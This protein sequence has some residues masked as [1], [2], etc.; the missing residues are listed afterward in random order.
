MKIMRTIG[1]VLTLA[2]TAVACAASPAEE[3]TG[4]SSSAV[5]SCNPACKTAWTDCQPL[6][7]KTTTIL[8]CEACGA[9]GEAPCDSSGP[10]PG[11]QSIAGGYL[12]L[13]NGLCQQ[14]GQEV[15]Q[16]ACGGASGYCAPWDIRTNA[17]GVPMQPLDVVN[18]VCT[19]CGNAGQ[20]ACKVGGS[21]WCEVGTISGNECYA[22]T[23][24]QQ[25]VELCSASECNDGSCQ[26]GIVTTCP[27]IAGGPAS[28][29]K[30]TNACGNRGGVST[31]VGCTIE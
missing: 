6:P 5:N 20:T 2:A 19:A 7:N 18:S 17:G 11:C 25:S 10:N 30:C 31:S 4:S 15:G 14:C 24:G 8:G 1:L 12:G 9:K 23:V 13:V 26:P 29:V 22:C 28:E 21:I 3:A 16:P 27:N